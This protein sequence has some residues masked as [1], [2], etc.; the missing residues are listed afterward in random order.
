MSVF[1][2]SDGE[3]IFVEQGGNRGTAIGTITEDGSRRLREYLL[4]CSNYGGCNVTILGHLDFCTERS[5]WVPVTQDVCLVAEDMR[6]CTIDQEMTKSAL[7]SYA[8]TN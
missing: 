7:Q 1:Y 8:C 5:A 4:R 3:R 6:P 2:A